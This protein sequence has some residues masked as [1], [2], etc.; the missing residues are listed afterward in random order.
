MHPEHKTTWTEFTW[1]YNRQ[2]PPESRLKS[3]G[4][5]GP[6]GGAADILPGGPAD[7]FHRAKLLLRDTSVLEGRHDGSVHAVYDGL[8]EALKLL[9]AQPPV[10]VKLRCVSR[11]DSREVTDQFSDLGVRPALC[12]TY[13]RTYSRFA[14]QSCLPRKPDTFPPLPAPKHTSAAQSMTL[15]RNFKR[16]IVGRDG[17][18]CY[19][20]SMLEGRNQ[21]QVTR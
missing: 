10:V 13:L 5:T 16:R 19:F 11:G 21:I 12:A 6:A 9:E 20:G 15:R 4:R 8:D 1:N 3:A 17:H 7:D 18:D 2:G 14:L